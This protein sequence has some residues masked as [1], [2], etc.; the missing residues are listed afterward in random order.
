MIRKGTVNDIDAVLKITNACAQH[1]ISQNIFQWNEFYPN[2]A[3][4]EKDVRREE[5]Y[6]LQESNEIKGCITIS[7]FMDEEYQSVNWLTPNSNNIYIHRLAI[8]PNVQGRGHARL[9][10]DYAESFAIKN[11][12]WSIRL[13]TFSQNQRNKKFYE[14]RGYKKTGEIYFPRQSEHP[15]YCYEL[16][17]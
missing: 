8:D 4:F 7:T 12:Y 16:V 3:P 17:L 9:L 15:F 5:L 1:L 6:V 2:K 14:L 11:N 13:D 10:M